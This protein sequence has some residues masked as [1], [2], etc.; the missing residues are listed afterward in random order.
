MR[1]SSASLVYLLLMDDGRV[2]RLPKSLVSLS[3]V[4]GGVDE[5]ELLLI[6]AERGKETGR[7][8]FEGFVAM[9]GDDF[10]WESNARSERYWSGEDEILS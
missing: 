7:E 4:K 3:G 10:A 1:K 5:S 8:I 6:E 9:M 2:P